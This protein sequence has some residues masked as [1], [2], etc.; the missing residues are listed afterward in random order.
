MFWKAAVS[1][2]MICAVTGCSP[3]APDSEPTTE[4]PASDAEPTVEGAPLGPIGNPFPEGTEVRLFVGSG[5]HDA[6][7][8]PIWMRA[9]GRVLTAEQRGRFEATLSIAP[10]PEMTADCFVPHHFFRYYDGSGKELGEIAVC[11][12][13]RG[14]DIWPNDRVKIG[15]DQILDVDLGELGELVRSMGEPT[16]VGCN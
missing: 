4:V 11:F 8:E 5:N 16:E 10:Y 1:L 6:D 12:C 14:V 13:C 15:P 3:Q 7:G 2:L 9:Q